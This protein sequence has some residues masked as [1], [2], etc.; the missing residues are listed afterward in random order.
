MPW[1]NDRDKGTTQVRTNDDPAGLVE[2][3]QHGNSVTINRVAEVSS[4]TFTTLIQV[5]A[6]TNVVVH[7]RVT[8]RP[9]TRIPDTTTVTG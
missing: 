2:R 7:S 4:P 3:L 1:Y 9:P 5:P 6:L 8:V